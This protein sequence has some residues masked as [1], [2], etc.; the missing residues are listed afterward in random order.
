[1]KNKRFVAAVCA[2][3]LLQA[4]GGCALNAELVGNIIAP[5][6]GSVQ[7]TPG[8]L[9]TPA[10][11]VSPAPLP[12]QE[13]NV[14]PSAPAGTTSP[15]GQ[16]IASVM[17]FSADEVNSIK[18]LWPLKTRALEDF[19]SLSSVFVSNA[20]G[21]LY[22]S[23]TVQSDKTLS[24]LTA[25]L[26][27]Y[28]SGPWSTDGYGA[29]VSSGTAEGITTDCSVYDIDVSRSI[30]LAFSLYEDHKEID[31]MLDNHW[32]ADAIQTPPELEGN[33][34]SRNVELDPNM[35]YISYEWEFSGYGDAFEWFRSNLKS[36]DGYAYTPAGADDDGRID[37]N[38]DGAS[39]SVTI[40]KQYN[41]L[42]ITFISS[43][44]NFG[45]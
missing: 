11:E 22:L 14:L 30:N 40:E 35:I 34:Y 31:E 18:S 12:S 24:D 8:P 9:K 20:D 41:A 45:L 44:A 38:L 25:D 19:G 37:F 3:A 27:T 43:P 42:D 36:M 2:I 1:M 10:P 21:F 6:E 28:I 23:F 4:L 13:A 32:P 26:Q 33:L 39:A 29:S 17:L 15:A 5:W 16:D 7:E